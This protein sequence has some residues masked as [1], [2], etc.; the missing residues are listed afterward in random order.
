MWNYKVLIVLLRIACFAKL[1]FVDVI[2]TTSMIIN[3]RRSRDGTLFG[4]SGMCY[5]PVHFGQLLRRARKRI[6]DIMKVY[7]ERDIMQVEL[8][9]IRKKCRLYSR[10]RLRIE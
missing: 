2:A 5:L 7:I 4:C 1:F 9:R 10:L 6:V 3:L 8:I